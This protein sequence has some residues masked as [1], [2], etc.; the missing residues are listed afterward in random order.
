MLYWNRKKLKK[1]KVKVDLTEK[2]Y[3]TYTGAVNLIKN[4]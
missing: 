3:T 4:C 2:R 1:T